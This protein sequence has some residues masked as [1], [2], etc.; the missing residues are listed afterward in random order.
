MWPIKKLTT[1]SPKDQQIFETLTRPKWDS[2]PEKRP[3]LLFNAL[4]KK[5][6]KKDE[7]KKK[8]RDVQ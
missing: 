4:L 1:L 7:K 2:H 3:F 8:L 5:M 6:E